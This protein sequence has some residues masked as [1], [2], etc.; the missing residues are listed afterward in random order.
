MRDP[1]AFPER[2]QAKG[3]RDKMNAEIEEGWPLALLGHVFL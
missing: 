1:A 3:N 2:E